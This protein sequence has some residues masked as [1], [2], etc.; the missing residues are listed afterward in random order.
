MSGDRWPVVNDESGRW[1]VAV[2]GVG[3]SGTRAVAKVLQ[4]AGVYLGGDLNE[5]LDNRW[6]T[7]LFKRPGWF[8]Q[9]RNAPGEPIQ[10]ALSV[11]HGVMTKGRV[12][13]FRSLPFLLGAAADLS[14]SGHDP[15]GFAKGLWPYRRVGSMLRARPFRASQHAGWG[16]K[17][18]NTHLLLPELAEHFPP[19]RYVHVVR[20]GLDMA[21]SA[22]QNQLHNWGRLF[23]VEPP[24]ALAAAPRSS[25]EFWIRAN[26]RAIRLGQSLLGSHFLLVDADQ[27]CQHPGAGVDRLVDFLALEVSPDV[28]ARMAAV[29][30]RPASAGRY[31]QHDLGVF[32]PGQVEAVRRL[33]FPV[34]G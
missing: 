27:L 17:E 2:G 19:L 23:D 18:P 12:A 14:R 13:A 22:N 33:G 6:F 9:A 32:G 24:P 31:R 16:W 25:L 10:R 4:L 34:E 11:F 28:R 5:A 7:L 20:H 26:E 1:P 8:V 3:G 21:F 29:P 30:R 15:T